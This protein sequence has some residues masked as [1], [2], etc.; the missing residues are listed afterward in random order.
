MTPLPVGP[1]GGDVE[2]V[3]AAL[4]VDPSQILD[5]S[6]SLNP[7]APDVAEL[8]AKHL[9]ALGRYPDPSE[10][11][12]ALADAV[13]VPPDHVLMT[14]GGSE[15]IALVCTELRRGVV[16]PPEFS[17]YARHLEEVV[18][19]DHEDA[20]RMPRIAS[21]PNNPTGRLAPEHESAAVWD[22]AFY[23]LA[24][25]RWTR[26]DDEAI[27]VGSLTKL[28]ACPGLRV[29]YV[30]AE[31]ELIA[32]LASLL[33]Q[34]SLNGLAASLV[35]ELLARANLPAWHEAC[36]V[37]R[38]ALAAAIPGV[39]PSDAPYVLVE[40]PEGAGVTRALLVRRG[41]LVRDCTSFGLPNHIRVAVPD[42]AGLR[43]LV[44]AWPD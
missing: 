13:D 44:A 3:A 18:D 1:H 34:W 39:L 40:T 11:T 12:E 19:K 41:V 8:A 20:G 28:F 2:R 24:T 21:N 38:T 32:R 43:K 35:P 14:N 31:P 25:G 10:A 17:L 6:V 22:E 37:R 42:D 9:D 26:G 16:A 27:V 29:G 7:D 36:T 4:N 5:L 33:P 15:A 23:P 30:L